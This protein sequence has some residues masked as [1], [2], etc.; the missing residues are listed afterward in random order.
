M[1]LGGVEEDEGK[2]FF[3][4]LVGGGFENCCQQLATVTDL[5]QR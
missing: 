4:D 2:T 1:T 3:V 5:V